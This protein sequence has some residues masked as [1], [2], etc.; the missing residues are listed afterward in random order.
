MHDHLRMIIS[1]PENDANYSQRWNLIKSYFSRSTEKLER[2]SM[3]RKSK[4]ER[5]IW[6]G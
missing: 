1:L 5:E 3:S 2:I 6:Q 4:R